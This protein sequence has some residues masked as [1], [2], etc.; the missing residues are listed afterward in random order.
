MIDLKRRN[1]VMSAGG[2]LAAS[3]VGAPAWGEVP[4]LSLIHI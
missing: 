4:G 3:A 2:V 1:L